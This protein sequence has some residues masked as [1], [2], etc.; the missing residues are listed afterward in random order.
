[1]LLSASNQSAIKIF[2][3]EHPPDEA[4]G[5]AHLGNFLR[6]IPLPMSKII[7]QKR[8]PIGLRQSTLATFA[9]SANTFVPG[10]RTVPRNG[11]SRRLADDRADET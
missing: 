2:L 10:E 3:V 1:M 11:T 9:A 4:A 5:S 8:R 6:L 7:R